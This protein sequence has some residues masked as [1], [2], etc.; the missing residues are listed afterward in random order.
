MKLNKYHVTKRGEWTDLSGNDIVNTPDMVIATSA[1][2]A[3]RKW[4]A[5]R[6]TNIRRS[7]VSIRKVGSFDTGSN[8][9]PCY[10]RGVKL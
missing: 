3:W 7:D 2:Q 10:Q 5:P 8:N 1:A 9:D 4:L 6:C